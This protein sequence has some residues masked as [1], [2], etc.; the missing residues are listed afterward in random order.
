MY[1]DDISRKEVVM[2]YYDM[3]NP[4][5]YIFLGDAE[6]MDRIVSVFNKKRIDNTFIYQK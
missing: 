3:L 1:F 6:H 2:T 5:G 4:D